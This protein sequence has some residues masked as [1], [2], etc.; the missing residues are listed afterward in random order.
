[1]KTTKSFNQEYIEKAQK[2]IYEILEDKKEY[3]DWTQIC[4]SMQNAVQAAANI[5]G[6]SSDE[7]INKMR[8]FVTEMVLTE[9][10]NLRQFDIS[11]KKKGAEKKKSLDTLYCSKCGS[12]NVE[13][14][15]WVNPNTDETSYND[16]VEEEDCWCN[17]CEEHV[18][19]C[20][21]SELWEMFGDIPVNNDDEIEEDFLNFPARTSKIDVWHWFDERCPNNL[22][23][24][25]KPIGV[26]EVIRNM[27]YE[28]QWKMLNNE[29]YAQHKMMQN[30]D[31]DNFR[32]RNRW[33]NKR[34]VL[35]MAKDYIEKLKKRFEKL[36]LR[37]CKGVP[38]KRINGQNIFVDDFDKKVIKPLLFAVHKIQHAE[39]TYELWHSVQEFNKRRIKMHWGTPQNAAWLDAYKGAGAFFTMQNMIRF[40][41]CVIIDDNG[42]TLSKNASLAFLN[43]KAKLYE[44]REGW[45][46]I[47][48]LKKTLDDNNIDVV[49]KM[50][51][52]RK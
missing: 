33:F 6:I 23:G 38:Y 20:T 50:K 15:A 42:K 46:L 36:K 44:N 37:K 28:Y 40:H 51:E 31:V 3:D 41:N 5:W 13:E 34:V 14:R 22:H 12:N 2:L 17:I 21:L 4:F 39:N 43:K 30:G 24:A 29:L 48:M 7:Q 8:A 16:S 45:R 1:M 32:D 35:D 19:L 47:G 27:G 49:A 52:W 18:E 9:L 25:Y 26:S 11:F 10:S